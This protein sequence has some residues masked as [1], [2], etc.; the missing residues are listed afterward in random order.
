MK[1]T[2]S[3]TQCLS[4]VIHINLLILLST[5]PLSSTKRTFECVLSLYKY[6][7]FA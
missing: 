1:A 4:W 2:M 3:T 7:C 5:F 6:G